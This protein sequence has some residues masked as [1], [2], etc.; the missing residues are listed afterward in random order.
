[1]TADVM[2]S[3]GLPSTLL[4]PTLALT[5][6]CRVT[7]FRQELSAA[8]EGHTVRSVGFDGVLESLSDEFHSSFH[9]D[10]SRLPFFRIIG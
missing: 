1:M 8:I 7:F 9:V 3:R 4:V 2:Y 6:V 5:S 10:R